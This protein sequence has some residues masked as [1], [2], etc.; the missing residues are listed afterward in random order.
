MFEVPKDFEEALVNMPFLEELT[1]SDCARSSQQ[2]YR[3]LGQ[4]S[5]MM[6]KPNLKEMQGIHH[7]V[8]EL[9]EDGPHNDNPAWG[10]HRAT[11]ARGKS[12]NIGPTTVNPGM[13]VHLSCEFGCRRSNP[14]LREHPH[15]LVL[16]WF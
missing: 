15:G 4:Y 13:A 8:F 5:G 10:R 1:L 11:P 16:N 14:I 7:G 9:N 2:L 3:V 6:R 12:L